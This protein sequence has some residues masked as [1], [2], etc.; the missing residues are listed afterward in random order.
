LPNALEFPVRTPFVLAAALVAAATLPGAAAS[1]ATVPTVARGQCEIEA[2]NGSAEC[3]VQ[4]NENRTY[5]IWGMTTWSLDGYGSADLVCEVSGFHDH[6][7]GGYGDTGHAFP[8]G[9]DV[10]RLT[11]HSSGG[12][13]TADVA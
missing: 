13:S 4:L 12:R 11:L 7:E 8:H 1:A 3:I 2:T 5:G 10:C 6:I 9:I